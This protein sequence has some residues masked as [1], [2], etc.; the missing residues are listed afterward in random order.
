MILSDPLIL[1]L[2]AFV[3]L[4]QWL[5]PYA[6]LGPW[7]FAGWVG[8]MITAINLLPIGQLDGGH[9]TNALFPRHA[10]TISKGTLVIIMALG[11]FWMGWVVWALLIYFL[12]AFKSIEVPIESELTQRSK[13]IAVVASVV[14]LLC[15]MLRPIYID[16][17][18]LDF[19]DWIQE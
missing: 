5:H 3:V 12:G 17:V 9:I 2:S 4:G 1:E 8:C 16:T 18:P 6:E 11:I 14:F 7:S 10:G 13:G 15:I 19:V